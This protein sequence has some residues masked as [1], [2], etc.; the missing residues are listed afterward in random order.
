MTATF[1]ETPQERILV[2]D[3]DPEILALVSA[4]LQRQGYDVRSASQVAAA[5]RILA[6]ELIDLI[7]LDIMMPGESGLSLCRR[8]A[9][10]GHPAIIILSALAT[11]VDRTIGLEVGA[12]G[13]LAKPCEPRELLATVRAV[14]RR[15]KLRA[16]SGTERVRVAEFMGWR[17]DLLTRSLR[18]PEGVLI[19]LSSSEFFLLRAF[20]DRPNRILTRE[21]L[22]DAAM[23]GEAAVYD[24]SIDVQ[25][26]RLRRKFGLAGTEIVK[27]VRNGGYL[28]AA[29]VVSR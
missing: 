11:S 18:S 24:R 8:L 5:E 16:E 13:Y 12:D 20:I 6:D 2:V 14:L 22:L 9:A 19:N 27:T 3:D 26:S 4:S 15:Y 25:V 23:L 10:A 21:Q 1:E 29:A 7:V 28:F 17:L